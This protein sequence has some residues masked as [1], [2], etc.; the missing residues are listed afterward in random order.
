MP[1][2]HRFGQEI[3]G[4]TQGR[5]NIIAKRECGVAVR[6]LAAE[7]GRSEGA[8]KYTIRTYANAGTTQER[9]HSGRPP[10]LS[11]HQKK[12]IYLQARAAPKL[13][14]SE[15]AEVGV[16]VQ[17]DGTTSKPP[18]YSTLYWTLKRGGLTNRRSKKRPKLNRGNVAKRL[19]FCRQY[20]HFQWH[21]R[22]I[23]FSD[24]C[25]VQKGSGAKQE[26]CF[27][28]HWE[29]WKPEMITA[30]GTSRKPQQ[31]A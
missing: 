27:R 23:K 20:R 31:M 25:S 7:F 14:Y 24:E 16:L 11:L 29:R 2:P 10:I 3:A 28:F 12:I 19:Q 9:P 5:P 21:Q 8:I 26:W 30:V 4:N 22:A 15:L 1:P 17:P 18:S 6:E 13:E